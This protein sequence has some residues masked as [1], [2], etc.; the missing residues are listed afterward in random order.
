MDQDTRIFRLEDALSRLAEAQVCTEA[1]V[2]RL[3]EAQARTEARLERVEARLEQ[4]EAALVRLAEAQARTEEQLV[5]QGVQE[6][7]N[8][9]SKN[10]S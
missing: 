1:A 3:A 8:A 7:A 5:R 2:S 9:P 6:A 10:S 4:A